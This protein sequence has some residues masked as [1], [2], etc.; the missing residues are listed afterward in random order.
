MKKAEQSL[1]EHIAS[2]KKEINQSETDKS[3]LQHENEAMKERIKT[4]QAQASDKTQEYNSLTSLIQSLTQKKTQVQNDVRSSQNELEQI[5]RELANARSL[6]SQQT[7]ELYAIQGEYKNLQNQLAQ[8]NTE[9]KSLNSENDQLRDNTNT[10]KK[11]LSSA[12][13]IVILR[14]RFHMYITYLAYIFRNICTYAYILNFF[15]FIC[16]GG[17]GFG[18]FDKIKSLEDGNAE[19][20][21]EVQKHEE[22]VK[23]PLV[24]KENEQPKKRGCCSI[25]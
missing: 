4:L 21:V 25:L 6:L 9:V 19:L 13:G 7:N 22:D 8:Q 17:I 1:R 14:M 23:I 20:K 12:K 10:L 24:Q 5:K 2:L 16:M 3:K 18:L 11:Q 15:V